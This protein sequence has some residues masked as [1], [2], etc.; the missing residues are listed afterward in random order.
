M[1]HP[2]VLIDELGCGG[3]GPTKF[4]REIVEA[5]NLVNEG[6]EFPTHVHEKSHVGRPRTVVPQ[7]AADGIVPGHEVNRPG[8]TGDLFARVPHL[9][10]GAIDNSTSLRTPPGG[11]SRCIPTRTASTSHPASSSRLG[12]L[13]SNC[14]IT[15]IDLLARLARLCDDLGLDTMEVGAALG[16]KRI[17]AGGQRSWLRPHRAP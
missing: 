8:F 16:V 10:Q 7:L 3:V 5:N 14:G 11:C 12:L 13:G 2:V 6:P 9:R 15:D 1:R 17:P 4:L